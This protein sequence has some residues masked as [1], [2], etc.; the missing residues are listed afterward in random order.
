MN[1]ALNKRFVE[2]NQG[3][4]AKLSKNDVLERVSRALDQIQF[5]EIVIKIQGGKPVWV[6]K[7]ERERV[8]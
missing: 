5:G 6:D 8:G 7:Y 1:K 2:K 4:S 3:T